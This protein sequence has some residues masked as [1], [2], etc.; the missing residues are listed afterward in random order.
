MW[1][2]ERSG[3]STKRCRKSKAQILSRSIC[4]AQSW[5]WS[6]H[7]KRTKSCLRS[8]QLFIPTGQD[9]PWL[10]ELVGMTFNFAFMKYG[11]WWREIGEK[12][13]RAIAAAGNSTQFLVDQLPILKYLPG[14][15]LAAEG[16]AKSCVATKVL[17]ALE[18]EGKRD[19]N[20]EK[21]LRNVLGTMYTAGTD[22]ISVADFSE[23]LLI[24]LDRPSRQSSLSFSPWSRIRRL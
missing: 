16:I 8:D 13:L 24:R 18:A 15:L 20:R 10:N 9:S 17:S 6:I 19:L 21:I 5:S 7:L 1:L 23:S 2:P 11:D 14:W 12:F 3:S 22:T 4:L